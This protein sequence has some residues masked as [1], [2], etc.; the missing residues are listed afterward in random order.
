[1]P[2]IQKYIGKTKN[3]FL[4]CVEMA[5]IISEDKILEIYFIGLRILTTCLAPPICGNDIQP[6]IIDKVLSEFAPI[7]IKK[8][9][10]LNFK[11]RDVSLHTLL[12]IFKHQSGSL[13]V[14]ID[15]CMDICE[16]VSPPQTQYFNRKEI[17]YYTEN[18][19]KFQ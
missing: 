18:L 10:E 19:R 12:T 17:I 1:M 14:L 7:L 9:G 11:A 2:L 16:K 8:I 13:Q 5:R 15:S 4:A 3:L 6:A